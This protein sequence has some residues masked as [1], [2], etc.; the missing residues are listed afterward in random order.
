[1]RVRSG[2]NMSEQDETKFLRSE[3]SAFSLP[4]CLF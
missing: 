3:L 2:F 4:A 1:M